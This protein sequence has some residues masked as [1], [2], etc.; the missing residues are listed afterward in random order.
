[1]PPDK[2]HI[3]R[4]FTAYLEGNC[5]P[6]EEKFLWLWVWQ[7][8][9]S[10]KELFSDTPHLQQTRDRMHASIQA[11]IGKGSN[12]R[13][14]R[15]AFGAAVVLLLMV[16]AAV[17][18]QWPPSVG[19]KTGRS[20]L[21]V[22]DGLH[23][24]RLLLPDSTQVTL[25]LH[26]SLEWDEDFGSQRRRVKLKGEAY[27]EVYKDLQHPFVVST[28]SL[29]TIVLGT[30]FN[31]ES[32]ARQKEIRVSLVEGKVRV[33]EDSTGASILTPGQM[34][35]YDRQSH[36]RQV[37]KIAVDDVTAWRTGGLVFNNIPLAEALDRLAERHSL[38]IQYNSRQLDGKRV[39]ATFYRA[40]WQGALSN[41]LFLQDLHYKA[42]DSLVTIY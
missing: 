32:Y 37:Q 22:S 10:E 2:E 23:V 33:G 26:S 1:M 29:Q 11:R 40:T 21:A 7:L 14:M 31:I 34:V 12:R 5:S 4:L 41:I 18:F 38:R 8:D 25:N 35:R 24:K 27:F 36:R 39:T 28:D 30:S 19:H 17:I 16:S 9:L 20:M 3:R 42:K 6:E 15:I 13:M